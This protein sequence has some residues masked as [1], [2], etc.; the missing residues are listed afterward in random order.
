MAR[1][2][3]GRS[4]GYATRRDRPRPR[5]H[6]RRLSPPG[7]A[8]Q[9]H[10]RCPGRPRGVP[11]GRTRERFVTELAWR[12][13]YADVLHHHPESLEADLRP[14]LA[15][16]RYEDSADLVEAWQQGRTGFPLV[17]AGM[18]QLLATGWMH[19][20]VRMVAASFLTKDLHVWWPAGARWFLDHLIDGDLA[21]NTHGWQWVAGTGTDAGLR[22]G[23]STS[24][25]RGCASSTLRV[26]TSGAGSLSWRT[27]RGATAHEASAWLKRATHTATPSASSITGAN[28]A[29]SGR[30]IA[31]AEVRGGARARP[32]GC[33]GGP[34]RSGGRTAGLLRRVPAQP[35][36]L[37][38]AGASAGSVCCWRVV[39]ALT[40]LVGALALGGT[41]AIR[42]GDPQFYGG[43]QRAVA[44]L[45]GGRGAGVRTLPGWLGRAATCSAPRAAASAQ[46]LILGAMLLTLF[47]AAF[48]IARILVLRAPV[49]EILTTRGWACGLVAAIT[50]V[51]GIAEELFFRG[52]VYAA[53]GPRW[54]L[55]G[56]TALYTASTLFSGV[57][58]LIRGGVPGPAHRGAARSR[59][60]GR[61][62]DPSPPTSPGRS[63]CSSCSAP[64]SPWEVDHG[65]NSTR[66]RRHRHHRRSLCPPCP[67]PAGRCA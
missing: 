10:C 14:A 22:F 50:V 12:E 48:V 28:A 2:P 30:L 46:G 51:N 63:G 37:S 16:I 24:S 31:I 29:R 18:R 5:R 45:W 21:S 15:G 32:D 56:S 58:L 13:F 64:S 43:R 49:D 53:F 34:T 55:V 20:R 62:L 23:C 11:E 41:L 25:C 8:S 35:G 39:V 7:S 27:C 67:T 42:P 57:P 66:D 9:H 19:N 33:A 44:G 54:D 65:Q 52:A 59:T 40:V 61:P 60:G 4:A 47:L 1:L 38:L 17:D 26:T 36:G 6:L 3:R